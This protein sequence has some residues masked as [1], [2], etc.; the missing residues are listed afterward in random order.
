M[1]LLMMSRKKSWHTRRTWSTRGSKS[2]GSC[3]TAG[4]A[5]SSRNTTAASAATGWNTTTETTSGSTCRMNATVCKCST[6]MDCGPCT[7]CINRKP[8]K[9]STA[10]ETPS[11]TRKITSNRP[12]AMPTSG[13]P[14]ST[15]FPTRLCFCPKLPEKFEQGCRM[16]CPG[17]CRTTASDFRAFTTWKPEQSCTKTLVSSTK[18][19]TTL[20]PSVGTSCRNSALLCISARTCGRSTHK[21]WRWVT[22]ARSPRRN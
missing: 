17:W 19:T 4:T 18:S 1:L 8:C 15:I 2:T 3:R 9:T 14:S 22:S 16:H 20:P 12:S 13:D 10:S 21:P 7:Q 11:A 6:R 5:A